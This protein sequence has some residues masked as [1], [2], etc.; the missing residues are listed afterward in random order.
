M[1]SASFDI[2]SFR[3]VTTRPRINNVIAVPRHMTS[4]MSTIYYIAMTYSSSKPRSQTHYARARHVNIGPTLIV[5]ETRTARAWQS[6]EHYLLRS[7]TLTIVRQ[8]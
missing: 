2:Q 7:P 5:S 3:P 6:G 1:L 8:S 4:R